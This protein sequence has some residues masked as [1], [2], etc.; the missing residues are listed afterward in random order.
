MWKNVV[1]P[2]GLQITV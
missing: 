1:D 2:G